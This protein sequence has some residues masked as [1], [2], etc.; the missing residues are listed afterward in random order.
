MRTS[1]GPI[2]ISVNVAGR[3]FIEGDLE[4]D[5]GAALAAHDIPASLLELELTESSLMANTERTINTLRSLTSRGVQISIDDFG[6]GYSSLAYLRRFPIDKLKIDIAFVR[7]ITTNADDAAIALTIIRMAHSLKL[8]VIAEGVETAEQFAYLRH[9]RCDQMQGFYFSRPLPASDMERM[10]CDRNALPAL[11]HTRRSQTFGSIGSPGSAFVG[12]GEAGGCEHLV[13]IYDDDAMLMETLEHY[14]MVG[15]LAG[16]AAIVVATKAHL[17]RLE[18]QLIAEGIDIEAVRED[19]RYIPLVADETL[20]LFM[21]DGMPDD[22]LFAAALLP[23][24]ARAQKNGRKVRGFGGMAALTWAGNKA[25]AAR[26][27]ALWDKL[28]KEQLL[29]VFCAY[30]REGF[31]E[32]R[33]ESIAHVCAMHSRVIE[34]QQPDSSL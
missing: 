6:T 1:V 24:L 27:E 17:A 10:L 2:Q 16:E 14:I 3:Q 25:A 22:G 23:I 20:A 34:I 9:H 12:S 21:K 13:Q 15:L 33:S 4:G 11:R 7:N 31:A 29:T 26:L 19:D 18:Q 30:P 5:V 28:C 8:E 32:D